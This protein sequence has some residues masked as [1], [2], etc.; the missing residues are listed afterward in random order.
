MPVDPLRG[1]VHA[2]VAISLQTVDGNLVNQNIA[3]IRE[4]VT[5]RF[6]EP[7]AV[8]DDQSAV[9]PRAA[10][11]ARYLEKLI[12]VPIRVPPSREAICTDTSTFFSPNNVRRT[13]T[14]SRRFVSACVPLHRTMPLPRG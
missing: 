5:H 4:S 8:R 7:A 6:P 12:Q 9:R 11:G 1:L 14:A 10:V 2:G 13:R 3:L